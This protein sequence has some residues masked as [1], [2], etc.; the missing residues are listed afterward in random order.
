MTV[1]WEL[2]YG[3]L[4]TC[5]HSAGI[6]KWGTLFHGRAMVSD[7]MAFVC[8]G[9][10]IAVLFPC[11]DHA[12][13]GWLLLNVTMLSPCQLWVEMGSWENTFTLEYMTAK[14]Q[15]CVLVTVLL[16]LPYSYVKHQLNCL[17]M[18]P[19][20]YLCLNMNTIWK[21]KESMFCSLIHWLFAFSL[22]R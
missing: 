21:L 4:S 2:V 9:S 10:F 7:T 18:E 17:E 20:K 8:S 16:W 15:T 6:G 3:Q 14:Q 11:G 22:N 5:Q 1:H 19:L 13:S 12:F